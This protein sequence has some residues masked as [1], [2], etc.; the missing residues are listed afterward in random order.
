M[1][2]T[3][4]LTSYVSRAFLGR[5]LG[6][7]LGFAA[8]LQLLD[9]LDTA[10]TVLEGGRGATDLVTYIGLRLPLL[11]NQIVPLA[12]LIAALATLLGFARRSEIVAMKAAGVSPWNFLKLLAPVV[13]VIAVLHILLFG[14]VVPWSEQALRD[15]WASHVEAPDADAAA[16]PVWLRAGPDIVSIDRVD[17]AGRHLSGVTIV[18]RDEKGRADER[19][20]ARAADW[21]EEGEDGGQWTLRDVAIL[22]LTGGAQ[23]ETHRESMPWPAGP[24]PETIAF[25][26]D[27]TEFL[28]P[29]RSLSILRGA[30]SGTKPQAYYATQ[31][32]ATLAVPL[33]SFVMLLLAQPALRGLRRGERF[34]VGMAMGLALGLLFLLVQGLLSALG[35]TN[36]LPP[37]LAVWSPL[38]LFACIGG[39]ILLYLE[40]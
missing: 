30:W 15:W 14:Q 4:T 22:P 32:Q 6:V 40:E 10:S 24:A 23:A 13:A 29:Q 17:D 39:T 34:G 36:T 35:E 28:S 31:L 20:V 9:L 5:F 21:I 38:L 2:L 19:R 7:L 27:P 11:V 25:V 3:S 33:S 8:V 37:T 1:T 26:A 12:V 18:S 16:D